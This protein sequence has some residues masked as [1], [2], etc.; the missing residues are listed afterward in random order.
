[1]VFDLEKLPRVREL[2]RLLAIVPRRRL[3]RAKK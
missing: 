1:M 3:A 2:T